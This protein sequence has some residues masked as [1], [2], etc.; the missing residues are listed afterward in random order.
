MENEIIKKFRFGV[1]DICYKQGATSVQD[2][3][4]QFILSE[5]K[6]LKEELLEDYPDE[7]NYDIKK[8]FAK[9]GV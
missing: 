7:I 2:F 5:L 6:S 4:E 9:R 8:A 1:N 3:A